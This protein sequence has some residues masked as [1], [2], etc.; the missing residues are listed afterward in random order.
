[1]SGVGSRSGKKP[2]E[3]R[4][5]L[6]RGYLSKSS[7]ERGAKS[8]NAENGGAKEIKDKQKTLKDRTE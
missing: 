6:T 8:L 2:G 3:T 1:M 4:D 7:R 5:K